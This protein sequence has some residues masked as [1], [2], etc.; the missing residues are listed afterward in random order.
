MMTDMKESCEKP[1]RKQGM[2]LVL[3]LVLLGLITAL[4]VQAQVGALLNLRLRDAELQEARLREVL[5]TTALEALQRLADDDLLSVDHLSEPWAQPLEIEYP[6]GISV[7]LSI[8]DAQSGFDLNNL[9]CEMPSQTAQTP[10]EVLMNILTLCGDYSP[11]ERA[12]ALRDWIDPDSDGFF[13]TAYYERQEPP[14]QAADSWLNSWHELDFVHG[15]SY[16]YFLSPGPPP[17]VTVSADLPDC[18][19]VIPGRRTSPVPVNVNTAPR[20]V[21][22]GVVGLAQEEWARQVLVMRQAAPIINLEPLL[23]AAGPDP[24]SLRP[25]LDVKSSLFC[26]KASAFYDNHTVDIWALVKRNDSGEVSV[27]RWVM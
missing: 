6:S 24:D 13:E 27:I 15:F 4:V 16:A 21:L 25:M 3:V 8:S 17:D 20:E 1:S 22:A 18:L 7:W 26:V 2:V 19:T 10:A 9:Y 5:T 14:S 23:E 11:V 12:D